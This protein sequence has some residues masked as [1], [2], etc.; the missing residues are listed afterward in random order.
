MTPA[1]EFALLTMRIVGLPLELHRR[2]LEHGESMRRELFL[3][4]AQEDE[5]PGSVPSR[6]LEVSS[7]LSSRYAEFGEAQETGIE[8]AT[9]SGA[10]VMAELVFMLP[11]Q[12][13]EALEVLEQV[14]E[15]ADEWCRSGGLLT[16][17]TPPD[18]VTYRRWYF[19]N[20]RSQVA[21]GPPRP[22]DGPAA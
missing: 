8:K 2:A 21:G 4:L 22:W 17:A 12:A 5:R 19:D 10:S 16:L 7:M 11:A 1:H 18:L 9:A 3:L 15:E 6:L 13:A 14:L 20:L